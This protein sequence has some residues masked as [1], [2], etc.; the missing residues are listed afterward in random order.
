MTGEVY[1]PTK[2]A[3][4]TELVI[5]FS[6]E[7]VSRD[8]PAACARVWMEIKVLEDQLK[9][10]RKLLGE[11]IIDESSRVG[12]KT[13]H[14]EGLKATVV[15]PTEIQWDL[16][17][18]AELLEA[19]LPSDR[20][21]QLV[22]TDVSYKVDG[23]IVRQLEGSNPDYAAIIDRARTRFPKGLP[24]AKVEGTPIRGGGSSAG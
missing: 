8:D 21:E 22:K 5:P 19:G 4:S 9:D 13:L 10:L 24:Y 16:E 17:I 1:D 18:L 12:T 11:A 7:V 23:S 15:E 20:Y 3:A 14:F 6:G 2:P